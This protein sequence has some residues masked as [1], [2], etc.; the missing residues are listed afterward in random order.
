MANIDH[1]EG[2]YTLAMVDIGHL[3]SDHTLDSR[4]WPLRID[5]CFDDV[6]MSGDMGL[7]NHK[8]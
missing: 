1:Q 4:Y 2:V 8:L 7:E 5:E 3:E 6:L